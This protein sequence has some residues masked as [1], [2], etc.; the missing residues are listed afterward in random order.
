MI[1]F[2]DKSVE[3]GVSYSTLYKMILRKEVDCVLI[4][5]RYYFKEK[6]V[7]KNI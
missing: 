1:K 3:L 7:G 6:S 5:G 4:C 2:I